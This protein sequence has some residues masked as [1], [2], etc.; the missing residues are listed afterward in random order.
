MVQRI[1]ESEY[2]NGYKDGRAKRAK[3]TWFSPLLKLINY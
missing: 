3:R 2:N 1:R